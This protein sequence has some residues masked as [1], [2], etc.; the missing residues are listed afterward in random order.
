MKRIGTKRTIELKMSDQLELR[1]E[2]ELRKCREAMQNLRKSFKA[3]K[4]DE[5]INW[6]DIAYLQTF[7]ASAEMFGQAGRDALVSVLE[8][9]A[10]ESE[11]AS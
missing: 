8:N 5:A 10:A 4:L 11:A 9:L 2:G 6:L 3:G 7:A 1:V